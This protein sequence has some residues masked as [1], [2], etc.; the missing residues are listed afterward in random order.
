MTPVLGSLLTL[1]LNLGSPPQCESLRILPILLLIGDNDAA[2][3]D[4]VKLLVV[5]AD[6]VDDVE[7]LRIFPILLLIGDNDATDGA[8]VTFHV[9]AA[10]N[11][12]AILVLC[13]ELC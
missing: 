7:S 8:S 10:D 2:G 12:E 5:P 9:V 1:I 11:V 4:P 3:A 6:D 13:I